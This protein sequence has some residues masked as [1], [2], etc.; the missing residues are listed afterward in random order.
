[1][2][3]DHGWRCHICLKWWTYTSWFCS[4]WHKWS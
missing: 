4:S 3:I 2:E 1:M